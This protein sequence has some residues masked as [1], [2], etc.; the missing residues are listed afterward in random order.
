MSWVAREE[1]SKAQRLLA[2][3]WLTVENR[4][5]QDR[6]GE[7]PLKQKERKWRD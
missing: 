3:A 5:G 7:K 2:G 6:G 4:T 1:H